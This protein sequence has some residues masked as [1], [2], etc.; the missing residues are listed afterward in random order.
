MAVKQQKFPV[1]P[2]AHKYTEWLLRTLTWR[3]N[4][5]QDLHA[6]AHP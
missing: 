2:N 3:P 1:S 5:V 6:A 4:G